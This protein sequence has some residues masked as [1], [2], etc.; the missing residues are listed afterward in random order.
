MWNGIQLTRIG[1]SFGL[2]SWPKWI[3]GGECHRDLKNELTIVTI[4]HIG[5]CMHRKRCALQPKFAAHFNSFGIEMKIQFH[6]SIW[7]DIVFRKCFVD[8][9]KAWWH[10]NFSI[11][12]YRSLNNICLSLTDWN[13]SHRSKSTARLPEIECSTCVQCLIGQE[14]HHSSF[15]IPMDRL[16]LSLELRTAEQRMMTVVDSN[17]THKLDFHFNN[18]LWETYKYSYIDYPFITNCNRALLWKI[19]A[20]L[21]SI[22]PSPYQLHFIRVRDVIKRCVKWIWR[23]WYVISVTNYRNI[24]AWYQ[25][26][27]F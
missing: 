11:V 22:I 2:L 16:F 21:V 7:T 17:H 20:A 19:Q 10:S 26:C 5:K 4:V 13:L 3:K 18:F 12:A 23:A 14:E 6:Y 15:P 27:V 8:C 9:I 24:T 1:I 25:L